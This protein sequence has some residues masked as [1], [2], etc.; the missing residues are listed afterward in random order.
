MGN[1]LS[2][3]ER[4]FVDEYIVSNRKERIAWELNHDRKRADCIWRFAHGARDFLKHSLTHPVLIQ[5]GTL[6]LAGK[7]FRREIGNPQV[8]IMH[9][10]VGWDRVITDF[11]RALDDYLGSGPYIII[12]LAH[13]FAFIETES[14][15]ETH[16]FLYMHK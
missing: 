15:C 11:Q 6:V 16:E 8:Y 9:P 12:D 10:S 4:Y 3:E 2:A 5:N 7:N 1:L 13:T 14:C